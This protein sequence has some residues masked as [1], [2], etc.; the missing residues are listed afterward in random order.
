MDA[1]R[2]WNVIANYNQATVYVQMILG[3]CL[4]LSCVIA[5][6]G[7][8][9][10]LPKV[11]YG[12]ISLFLA[13]VF[14]L[15]YGTE[16]I[17]FFFAFPMFLV[18]GCVFFFEAFK[19]KDEEF[20]KFTKLQWILTVLVLIYPLV[21]IVQG[22]SFPEMLMYIMPCPVVCIGIILWQSYGSRNLV[23]LVALTIWGLTGVKAFFFDAYEDLILFAMGIL[24]L[25]ILIKEIKSRRKKVSREK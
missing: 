17:Q 22:K 12:G 21:S 24:A 18:L 7:K 11:V 9:T 1:E 4:I 2:F 3:I 13:I 14:F 5:R 10:W 20:C 15:I 23:S 8:A 16:P 25:V 19:H 6:K